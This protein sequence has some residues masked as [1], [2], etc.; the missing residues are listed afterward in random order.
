VPTHATSS[1]HIAHVHLESDSY[2]CMCIHLSFQAKLKM[3]VTADWQ[4]EHNWDEKAAC[5]FKDGMSQQL[6]ILFDWAGPELN[7]TQLLIKLKCDALAEVEAQKVKGK[8]GPGARQAVTTPGQ[9]SGSGHTN[10]RSM[11]TP[12]KVEELAAKKR[13][14]ELRGVPPSPKQGGKK[15]TPPPGTP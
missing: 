1:E 8:S 5:L 11:V 10:P 7:Y 15:A 3:P 4:I 13:R 12:D 2:Y 6:S 14:V 9:S